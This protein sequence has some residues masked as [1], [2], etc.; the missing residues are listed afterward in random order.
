MKMNLPQFKEKLKHLQ[1]RQCDDLFYPNSYDP[2][3]TSVDSVFYGP[4]TDTQCVNAAVELIDLRSQYSNAEYSYNEAVD[5]INFFGRTDLGPN[6]WG[7]DRDN[8][9][10]KIRELQEKNSLATIG[11]QEQRHLNGWEIHRMA[12][13]TSL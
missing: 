2:V 13:S 3:K 7:K 10:A 6:H 12:S 8:A 1:G 5:Q 9:K 11:Y 4:L